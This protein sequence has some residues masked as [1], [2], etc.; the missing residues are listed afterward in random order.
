MKAFNLSIV[1]VFCTAVLMFSYQNCTSEVTF[2]DVE[3]SS[4]VVEISPSSTTTTTTQRRP[5]D[6]CEN[7]KSYLVMTETE[8]M[9]FSGGCDGGTLDHDGRTPVPFFACM[10]DKCG[11]WRPTCYTRNCEASGDLFGFVGCGNHLSKTDGT[12]SPIGCAG[13]CR[14]E[15]YPW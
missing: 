12:R 8:C 15:D 6:P 1:F 5:V 7:P 4:E 9:A 13:R 11:Y 3:H 2:S 10:Q 14:S